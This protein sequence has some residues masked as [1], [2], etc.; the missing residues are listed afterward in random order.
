MGPADFS[1]VYISQEDYIHNIARKFN[2]QNAAPVYS[3]LPL[4]INFGAIAKPE[5]DDERSEAVKLPYKEII[6]SLMFATIIS[7]PDIAYSVNKLAQY[8]SNPG[9]G[10]WN[11]V[12]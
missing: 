9:H 8:S 11:L 5:T 7:R 4:G 3:P 2:L 12:K 1:Y 6:G 10:H